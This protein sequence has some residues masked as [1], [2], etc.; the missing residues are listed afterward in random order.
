M[1]FHTD[2]L[3]DLQRR[4]GGNAFGSAP[5]IDPAA[6]RCVRDL[7]GPT[8]ALRVP[9]VA[10]DAAYDPVIP[11]WSAERYLTLLERTGTRNSF[12][13]EVVQTEGH[14]NVSVPDRLRA[15]RTLVEWVTEF[16]RP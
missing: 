6:E 13:R 9:F 15:F 5:V 4:C 16:R 12:K 7:P 3:R 8:G 1:V 10:V 11:S 14:L 2:A